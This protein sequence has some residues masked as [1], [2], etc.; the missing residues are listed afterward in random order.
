MQEKYESFVLWLHGQSLLPNPTITVGLENERHRFDERSKTHFISIQRRKSFDTDWQAASTTPW[1][2]DRIQ[3]FSSPK[4]QINCH[5]YSLFNWLEEKMTR[6]RRHFQ[7]TGSCKPTTIAINEISLVI[8]LKSKTQH[9][10]CPCAMLPIHPPKLIVD[11]WCGFPIAIFT[12]FAISVAT[13][14]CE[15]FKSDSW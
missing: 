2:T 11:V 1:L 10:I 15:L 14:N 4:Q 9:L 12:M 6:N 8:F 13:S 5:H 3:H 7:T